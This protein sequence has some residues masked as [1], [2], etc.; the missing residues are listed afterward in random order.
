MTDREFREVTPGP[1]LT[2]AF[3][4]GETF[5]DLL[6]REKKNGILWEALYK[7]AKVPD[8]VVARAGKLRHAWHLFVLSEDW[9]GDSINTL[10]TIDRL[11][12][13][14]PHLDM[15]IIGRDANPDLMERH[16]TGVSRSIPVIMV[17]DRNY[18]ERGWWGPRPGPLQQ[19]VIEH[20]L[21]LPK[22]ERYREVRT[23]YARDHGETALNEL[24]DIIERAQSLE[25]RAQTPG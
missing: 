21:A 16:L 7:R 5:T 9:C 15:R 14:V 19:W 22:D 1:P 24:L 20:G 11:T 17:L 8:G 23:W 25:D 10:P 3:L 13:A 2:E 18:V 12:E 4:G 6:A